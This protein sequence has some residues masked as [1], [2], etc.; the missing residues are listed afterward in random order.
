MFRFVH[1]A[2]V[3]LD[4]PLKSLALR[5]PDLAEMVGVATRTAFRRAVDLCLTE[6]VDAFI[7]AGDLYDGSLRSMKTARYFGE[8]MRRLT[9]AGIPA[10]IIRG[11]H[12]AESIITRELTLPEGVHVFKKTDEPVVLKDGAVAV[13]GVSFEEP[14]AP[15]SLLSR[16]QPGTP[17]V[18]DIG[19]MHTSLDGSPNHD[20]Y[21]PCSTTNLAAH[22]YAYW[23]LGHIHKRSVTTHDDCTIVMPGIPQGRHMNE[24]GVKSISLTTI[25]ETGDCTVEE[26]YVAPVRFER[27]SLDVSQIGDWPELIGL[28]EDAFN[29]LRDGPIA[30]QD[31]IVRLTCTGAGEFARKMRH[32]R[33][34][35]EEELRSA[36]SRVG[37][38]HLE[39]VVFDTAVSQVVKDNRVSEL[40]AI[41]RGGQIDLAQIALRIGDDVQQLIQKLPGELRARFDPAENE[42]LIQ[43]LSEEGVSDLLAQI[44]GES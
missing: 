6:Q 43:D 24:D 1:T 25:T 29:S 34:R 41:V 28:T 18:I 33:E 5:D 31:V 38:V 39:Q 17:G 35:L 14:H 16:Y 30:D 26:K 11:N 4:S 9:E 8:E 10:F 32:D 40:S 13:H 27:Q 37:R 19:A 3:H 44:E 12:D 36:A 21:A 20:V 7:V 2:D 15:N 23:A 22:G 42:G